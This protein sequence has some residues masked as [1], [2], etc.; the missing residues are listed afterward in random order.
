MVK[1]FYNVLLQQKVDV[2]LTQGLF[3]A[4]DCGSMAKC[5]PV[6]SGG[7]HCGQMHQ[8]IHYLGD[9]VVLQFGGGT[10]GHPDGIQ[11]GATANRVA[12]ESMVIARNEG[13]D[14]LSEGPQIL[15]TAAKSCG[16]LQTALDLWKDITF[17]YAST[18][19]ADF[20]E[21]A[22]SNR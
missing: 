15:R 8:L 3:F 20:I 13:R 12:L 9:D 10:I 6:A 11:A 1:G 16:P 17:N 4:Q 14:Y 22:T 19:T 5:V 21:T 2:N 18:D 7:I